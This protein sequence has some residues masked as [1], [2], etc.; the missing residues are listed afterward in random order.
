MCTLSLPNIPITPGEVGKRWHTAAVK[1]PSLRSLL[2]K[3]SSA[4]PGSFLDFD[5]TLVTFI[6]LPYLPWFWVRKSIRSP[7]PPP[8]NKTQK[9]FPQEMVVISMVK[10]TACVISNHI[11]GQ[12][13]FLLPS[14]LWNLKGQRLCLPHFSSTHRVPFNLHWWGIHCVL[15]IVL[16][17]WIG[18]SWEASRETESHKINWTTGLLTAWTDCQGSTD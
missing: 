18:R 1:S 9:T 12:P 11:F 14:R 10:I 4:S 7:T 6:T 8:T 3:S 2:T 15:C 16:G 13:H 17:E 5:F